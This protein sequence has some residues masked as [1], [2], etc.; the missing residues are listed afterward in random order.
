M[1]L[2][3]IIWCNPPYQPLVGPVNYE[4]CNLG[5]C[6]SAIDISVHFHCTISQNTELF[7]AGLMLLCTYWTFDIPRELEHKSSIFPWNLNASLANNLCFW[8]SRSGNVVARSKSCFP[9][10]KLLT[11]CLVGVT[12][13]RVDRVGMMDYLY[14]PFSLKGFKVLNMM[15]KKEGLLIH[16]VH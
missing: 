5:T 1:A 13:G 12:R 9:L 14:L 7:Y 4:G 2:L 8:F 6:K 3:V 11:L 10:I 15:D 16:P